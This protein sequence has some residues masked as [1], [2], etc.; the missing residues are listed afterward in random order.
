METPRYRDVDYYKLTD[1]GIKLRN[2]SPA[3]KMPP[4]K[5]D[6]IIVVLLKR[7]GEANTMDFAYRI[8]TVVVYGSYVRGETFQSDVDIAVEHE[9]KWDSDE[10]RD[11]R[12][13]ERIKFAFASGHKFSNFIDKVSWPQYEVQRWHCPAFLLKC[14]LKVLRL[15]KFLIDASILLRAGSSR[16]PARCARRSG[17]RGSGL[18]NGAN[19]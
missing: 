1:K 4:A 12:K 10:A 2:A 5:S 6:Q 13:K 14:E 19:V 8:P 11:R 7:V 15:I 16:E 3:A 18:D 9:G 17:I